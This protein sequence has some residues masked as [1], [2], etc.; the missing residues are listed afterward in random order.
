MFSS[1]LSLDSLPPQRQ[2]GVE[3]AGRRKLRKLAELLRKVKNLFLQIDY[4]ASAQLGEFHP[5]FCDFQLT[6]QRSLTQASPPILNH[7]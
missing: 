2:S 6:P 5:A 4:F 3:H 1:R 7:G